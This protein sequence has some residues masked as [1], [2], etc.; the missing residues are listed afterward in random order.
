MTYDRAAATRFVTE[1]SKNLNRWP[2]DN[3]PSG[4]FPLFTRAN[5]GEVFPT[6]V[7]PFSWTQWGVPHSEPGWRQALVNLG[8]FDLDEFTPDRMEM[9]S[10]FGGY[11]YLNVSASRI[12][13]RR[14]PGLSPEA[15]DAS[16]FG[17]Q[18]D[19]PPYEELPGHDSARHSEQ[20]AETIA[21]VFSQPTLPELM[22]TRLKLIQ[23]RDSR[24]DLSAMD[25]LALLERVLELCDDHWEA[26]W[27][28]H[29]MATY[30]SMSPS[31]VIAQICASAGLPELAADIMAVAGEVDSAL[32]ARRLWALS[33]QVKAS[34]LLTAHFD[35]GIGEL[36][37][38]LAGDPA[39]EAQGFRFA[40]DAFL[41]EFG[42]RGEN[43]WEVRS[44]CWE[45]D[46]KAPLAAIEL[47]RRSEESAS[48]DAR[49]ATRLAAR[50]EAIATV[51]QALA[52]EGEIL[53]Q[54]QAAVGAAGLFFAAR[55]RTK[56][57]CAMFTHEMRM[58]MWTL[59]RRFAER[60]LFEEPSQFALLTVEEWRT[61]L[62]DPGFVP[63]L[64]GE[65][66]EQASM[67]AALKPPFIV[68][69]VVPP[70]DCWARRDAT[71]AVTEA[72]PVLQ[73][74]PGCAGTARGRA[75]LVSD[76]GEPGELG[77]ED[78]L[79]ARH[80]D[81]AWTPLFSAVSGVIV[82]VGAT[83]SHAVIV[84]RELGVPC[85]TSVTGAT[86]RIADGSLVEVDGGRGTVTLLEA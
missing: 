9:L 72:Q 62:R 67:L 43:E 27:V 80:T 60:G 44:R 18:P 64:V 31:G 10:V 65:R 37:E 63:D 41:R 17:E 48:P 25:D 84:A 8:A 19:V 51:E 1:T 3:D 73:G 76:P 59:G 61:A 77:P 20:L 49:M 32:P 54:F 34:D 57:N 58:P 66:A 14:A 83:V 15:I 50:S 47:M 68:N 5:I 82:E 39:Q 45:L 33:R 55:E 4:R 42:F 12:F 36:L 79:V 11:G 29:I 30:H 75:R 35:R 21:W 46:S 85:V 81:P 71:A 78:I 38:R 40:F 23:L 52:G 13:G 86:A 16:F 74:Q 26:L 6:V 53:T 56:T 69:G 22:E 28:R 7:M 24:P 70:L 2:V